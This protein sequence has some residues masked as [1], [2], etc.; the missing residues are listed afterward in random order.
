VKYL[1]DFFLAR[2]NDL[3]FKGI[4]KPANSFYIKD[5]YADSMIQYNS[6]QK[7]FRCIKLLGP[8]RA[9]ILD[10]DSTIS[11]EDADKRKQEIETPYG[12]LIFAP[13]KE[14]RT[15]HHNHIRDQCP[16]SHTHS[17]EG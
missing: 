17:Q 5:F 11:I 4:F 7:H 8:N 2:F 6:K 13:I 3:K 12:K 1:P 15:P 16:P 14:T 10:N 9:V